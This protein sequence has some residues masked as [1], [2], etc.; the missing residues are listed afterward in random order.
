MANAKQME[1]GA[2]LN[3]IDR[4]HRQ[5]AH[6]YVTSVN[7]DGLIIAKPS[8]QASRRPLRG[9]FMG[10]AVL[11]VFKAFVYAQIGSAAYAERIGLLEAGTIVEQIGAYVMHADPVTVWIAEQITAAF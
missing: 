5:L 3:K 10:L 2:R 7:H 1:F 9:V 8:R 11:L 4:S 6:G